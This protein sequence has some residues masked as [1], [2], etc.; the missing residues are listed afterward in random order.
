MSAAEFAAQ[1]FVTSHGLNNETAMRE[2]GNRYPQQ[3][4]KS[5]F[6]C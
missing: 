3:T 5:P 4:L 2:N 1:P 6:P